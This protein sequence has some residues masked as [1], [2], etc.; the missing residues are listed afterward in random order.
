ML[1]SMMTEFAA[2]RFHCMHTAQYC[3]L[4]LLVV[5][6]LDDYDGPLTDSLHPKTTDCML[7]LLS[8][9]AAGCCHAPVEW[10]GRVRRC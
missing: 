4:L 6:L 9:T 1:I 3:M 7:L 5:S 10:P 8:T 2:A